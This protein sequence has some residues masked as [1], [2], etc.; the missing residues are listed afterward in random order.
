[1]HRGNNRWTPLSYEPFYIKGIF[2]LWSNVHELGKSHRVSDAG[3]GAPIAAFKN[4]GT[5][6]RH[7]APNTACSTYSIVSL[8]MPYV[9]DH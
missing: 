7:G 5:G 9:H 6:F 1:M 4:W 3:L 8:S 2:N